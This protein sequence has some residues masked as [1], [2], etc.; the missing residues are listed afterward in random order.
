MSNR[1]TCKSCNRN[2]RVL[3]EEGICWFCYHHKYGATP[4]TGVYKHEKDKK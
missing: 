3:T 4:T 1:V 2:Y